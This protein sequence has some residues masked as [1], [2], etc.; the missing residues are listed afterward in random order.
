MPNVLIS[1]LSQP[2]GGEFHHIFT[3]FLTLPLTFNFI[4]IRTSTSHMMELTC[5]AHNRDSCAIIMQ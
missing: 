1:K 2:D 4:S 5:W 3:F